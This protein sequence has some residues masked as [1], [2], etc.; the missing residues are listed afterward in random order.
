MLLLI[1]SKLPFYFI[2]VNP[3]HLLFINFFQFFIIQ[4]FIFFQI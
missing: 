1:I 2:L 3:N 4:K